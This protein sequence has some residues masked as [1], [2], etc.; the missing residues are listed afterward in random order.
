M[1]AAI[2]VRKTG[3]AYLRNVSVSFVEQKLIGFITSHYGL[4]VGETFAQN[5]PESYAERIR[6]ATREKLIQALGSSD[7]FSPRDF[8]TLY[9][10]IPITIEN[11][12]ASNPFFLVDPKSLLTQDIDL[13]HDLVPDQFPPFKGWKGITK[14]PSSWLGVRSPAAESSEKIRNAVL[15]AL[16]LLPHRDERYVFSGREMFGGSVCLQDEWKVTFGSPSTPALMENIKLGIDDQPW[17]SLLAEKI[18]CTQDHVRKQLKALEYYYRAWSLSEIQRFPVLFMALDAL[19]GNTAAH[20]DAFGDAIAAHM[21]PTYDGGRT[22]LLLGLRAS[23]IHGGAPDVY[24][25]SKYSKYHEK[26]QVSPTSDL[27]AIAATCIKAVVLEGRLVSR[28]HTFA[29]VLKK[30]GR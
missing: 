13:S 23:V 19:F 22:K 20:A 6:G 18:V 28:A 25:S 8:V 24:D 30:L 21:G 29:D 5:F 2:F 27:E 26:Y 16:A 12:F 14:K 4:M 9:P 17:L 1:N 3:A 15:G 11:D 7:M 10:L